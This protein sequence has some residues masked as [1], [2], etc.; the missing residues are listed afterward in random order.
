MGAEGVVVVVARGDGGELFEEIVVG[1]AV[2]GGVEVFVRERQLG[3]GEVA[4]LKD[5]EDTLGD[6]FGVG[7]FAIEKGDAEAVGFVFHLSGTVVALDKDAEFLL[8]VVSPPRV[9]LAGE[10]FG[11]VLAVIVNDFMTDDEGK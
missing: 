10:H 2:V 9:V 1:E 5:I 11:G 4:V 6:V 3:E 8:F 7:A